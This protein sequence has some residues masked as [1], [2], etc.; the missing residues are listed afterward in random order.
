MRRK[1]PKPF[2]RSSRNCWFVQFGKE[3]IGLHT[4]EGESLKLCH[5]LMV[6]R[7]GQPTAPASAVV[8]LSAFELF[9][10]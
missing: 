9:D 8:G 4:D 2:W 1:F 7:D 5:E 10:K 3:Q 6:R